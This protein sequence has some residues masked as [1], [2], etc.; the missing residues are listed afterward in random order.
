MLESLFD[1][2]KIDIKR[3]ALFDTRP[4]AMPEGFDFSRIEGMMLGL[5]I[6]DSLGNTTESML[7]KNRRDAFGEIRDY[8]PNNHASGKT[9]GLPTDDTQLAFWT[10]EQ[11]IEDGHFNPDHVVKRLSRNRIFGIG[12]S[13]AQFLSNYNSGRTWYESGPKSSGNGALMRIAPILVPHLKLATSD[14]WV[15]AALCAMITHN[16]SGSIGACLSFVNILWH[17]LLM[18]SPP[19]PF[20]WLKTYVKVARELELDETYEPRG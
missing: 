17:L 10:L 6:G 2:C 13:V 16:D 3:G 20:W 19:E 15:D 14:L 5:A 1:Q 8:L 4:P 12:S 7:P 9:I 18:E 11:M